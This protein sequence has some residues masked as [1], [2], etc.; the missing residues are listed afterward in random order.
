MSE[1]STQ[2]PRDLLDTTEAGPAAIRGGALRGLGY[3]LGLLLSAGTVPFVVRHLGLVE[4]GHFVLVSSLMTLVGGLTEAGLQAVAVREYSTRS[5]TDRA[6]LM[7]NLLGLRLALTTVGVL[8]ALAFALIADYERT[9]VLGVVLA[10]AGLLIQST[11][12]LVVAPLAAE[13]RLGWTTLI[14]LIRQFVTVVL[15][16]GLIVVGASLLPFFAVA[17]PSGIVALVMTGWLVRHSISF[18][19]RFDGAEWGRLLRATFAFSVA[20]AVA[21]AYFRIGLILMSLISTELETAYFA[22]SFRLLEVL[23]PL[24]GLAIGA[25]FP[26][27][28]RAAR[29]DEARLNYATT[30]VFDVALLAGG[31]LIVGLELGA[32]IAIQILAGDAGDPAIEVLRIQAPAL[33]GT[34]LATAGGF[35]LLSLHRHREILWANLV[36]LVLAIVLTLALAPGMGANGAAIATTAAEWALALAVI[37]LLARSTGRVHLQARIAVPVA[38]GIAL[39]FSV[40][41]L[42]VPVLAQTAIGLA[43]YVAVLLVTRS[44]PQE[45]SQALLRR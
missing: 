36:A 5:D 3:G 27:L 10:G 45:L 8:I 15:T 11:Q 42:P 9:L 44:I 31:F 17:I 14:E 37:V 6:R 1:A 30:R 43:V 19:P 38:V 4:F 23:L 26:I 12:T 25:V 29:D 16:L 28:A 33:L 7:P 2:P 22:A 41:A 20:T 35:A 24:P 39:G 32:P 21:I 34:A 18:R 13:L 40:L